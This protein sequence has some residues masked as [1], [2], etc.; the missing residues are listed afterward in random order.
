VGALTLGAG[1]VFY[2]VTSNGGA[3]NHGTV[4]ELVL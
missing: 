2:G 1:K 3:S 4:Y